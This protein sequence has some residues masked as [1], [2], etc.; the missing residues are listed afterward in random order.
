MPFLKNEN[1]EFDLWA[2]LNA[3]FGFMQALFGL[4]NA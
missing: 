4:A 3:V 2:F 1:G